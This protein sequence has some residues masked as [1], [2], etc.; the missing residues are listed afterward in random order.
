MAFL[1]CSR[2]LGKEVCLAMNARQVPKFS[3]LASRS[4]HALEQLGQNLNHRFQIAKLDFATQNS[5][6]AILDEIHRNKISRVFYF[7]GGGPYGLFPSK[8][9]K[10]HMWSLQLSFLTPVEILF[11]LL[12]DARFEHVQQIVVVGSL[13]ADSKGDPHAASYAAAKHGL[14]GLVES[15]LG[16]G[17]SKDL[18]LFRPGYMDTAMLPPHATPRTNSAKLLNPV[19]AAKK[20][21]DWVLDPN[22]LSIFNVE[23]V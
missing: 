1:G 12:A 6:V 18:R 16:E 8:E 19:E 15:I 23:D 21:V 17:C 20:F 14:R 10:D 9:W 13:V 7:A 2:G 5:V 4:L 11:Q 3:L 22:G